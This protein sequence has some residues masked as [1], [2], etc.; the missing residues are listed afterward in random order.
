MWNLFPGYYIITRLFQSK[1]C[2]GYICSGI[3]H[4]QRKSQLYTQSIYNSPSESFELQRSN[5]NEN[6]D[7]IVVVS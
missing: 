2:V 6:F 7:L 3:C 5:V 4:I 1:T